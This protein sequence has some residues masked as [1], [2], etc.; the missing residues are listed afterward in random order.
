MSAWCLVNNLNWF[1]WSIVFGMSITLVKNLDGIED[2]HH[3]SL[4]MCIMAG[5]GWY[6]LHKSR[7]L[8]NF[9]I[10][11]FPQILTLFLMNLGAWSWVFGVRT[12]T[13]IVFSGFYD[14]WYICDLGQDIAQIGPLSFQAAIEHKPR[15]VRWAGCTLQWSL[16]GGQY[17][18][19]SNSQV[20]ITE[21]TKESLKWKTFTT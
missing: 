6:F 10:C 20:S 14:I 17:V 7:V 9:N 18:C 3:T 19:L 15:Q 8:L 2:G 13:L 11:I 4:N 12:I 5:H 16:S 1:H 21:A